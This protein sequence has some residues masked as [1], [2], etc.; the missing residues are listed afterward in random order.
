MASIVLKVVSLMIPTVDFIFGSRSQIS[1][2]SCYEVSLCEMDN[3][4]RSEQIKIGIGYQILSLFGI[5]V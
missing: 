4:L 5:Y 1:I 2:D 3:I